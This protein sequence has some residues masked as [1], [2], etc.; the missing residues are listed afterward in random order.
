MKRW[1]GWGRTDYIYHFTESSKA[2]V[3]K[4]IGRGQIIP[5]AS[6]QTTLKKVPKSRLP[7]NIL[8]STDKEVRLRHARGQSLPDW[9]A[10]RYGKINKFPDAVATPNSGRR[11]KLYCDIMITG[12]G[13]F[14]LMEVD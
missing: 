13:V 11:C 5:D 6:L 8:Y 2:F 9:I 1:N 12:V 14:R 3:E 7:E 4:M 10:L